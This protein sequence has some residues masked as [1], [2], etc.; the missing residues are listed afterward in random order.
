MKKHLQSLT[1]LQG[2][3]IDL[4]KTLGKNKMDKK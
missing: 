2:D 4:H 1:R 3:D